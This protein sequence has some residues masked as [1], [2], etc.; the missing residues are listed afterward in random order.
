[1]LSLPNE[2]LLAIQGHLPPFSFFTLNGPP[3][4]PLVQLDPS[5]RSLCA[6]NKRFRSVYYSSLYEIVVINL[7]REELESRCALLTNSV[8]KDDKVLALIK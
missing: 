3:Q 8:L 4:E 1:M 2:T 7:E 5:L 6:T